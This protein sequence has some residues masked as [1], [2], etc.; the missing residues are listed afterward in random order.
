MAAAPE[1][2][3]MQVPEVG[4]DI[5]LSGD[6]GVIK[7]ISQL[8]SGPLPQDGDEIEAHY[9]GTL[10]DGSKFDS[11]RDRNAT[12]ST[13]RRLL[14][15]PKIDTFRSCIHGFLTLLLMVSLVSLVDH[16]SQF[17]FQLG[18]GSVI[19]GWDIGFAS[20]QKGEKAVLTLS[21]DYAY[22]DSGSP[23]KIPAKATLLF[24]VELIGFGPKKKEKWELNSK[25]KIEQCEKCKEVGNASFKAGDFA[26]AI[27]VRRWLTRGSYFGRVC[28]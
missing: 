25:E 17:K 12:V 18:K 4:V 6:G 21:S 9:T 13:W 14:V 11:S 15:G 19:K 28:S 26:G 3:E 7:K 10:Q 16:H 1:D 5:D 22:G 8:G 2:V 24:D 23:P 20:M 27:A